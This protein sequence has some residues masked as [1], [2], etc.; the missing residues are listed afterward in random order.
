MSL[1]VSFLLDKNNN[2]FK[3]YYKSLIKKLP[4]KKISYN[5]YYNPKQIKNCDIVFIINYTKILSKKFLTQN[6][7]NLVIHCSKLPY[8]KGFA[9]LQWQILKNKKK[10]FMSLIEAS[11][12]VDSGDVYL[13]EKLNFDGT[14]LYDEIREK[15]ALLMIKLIFKFIKYYNV[16]KPIKQ[17]GKT[18]FFRKRNQSDS[19]L[20]IN[21]PVKKLFP[22]LRVVNNN[23]WPAF[24]YYKKIKYKIKIYKYINEKK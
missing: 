3:K 20:N 9:P 21:L 15:Q 16:L 10:I 24:F 8:G 2:W 13:V 4:K 1:K 12:K 14:E 11:E 17:S 23:H 22:L 7:K 5:F 6:K 19:K 18:T